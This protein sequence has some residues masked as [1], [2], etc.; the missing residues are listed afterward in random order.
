MKTNKRYR[1][2]IDMKWSFDIMVNAKDM[3]EAKKKAFE[4]FYKTKASKQKNFNLSGEED[5]Y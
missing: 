5:K 2:N 4:K 1:V 3:R